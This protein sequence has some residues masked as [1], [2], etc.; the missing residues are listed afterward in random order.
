[1]SDTLPGSSIRRDIASAYVVTA[2][3]V[4]AWVVVSAIIYRQFGPVALG[5]ITLVRATIGIL[6]YTSLGLGPAMVRQLAQVSSEKALVENVSAGEAVEASGVD[7]IAPPVLSYAAAPPPEVSREMIP[8]YATG[9]L[10]ALVSALVALTLALVYS[11]N[12][13]RLHHVSFNPWMANVL[14]A[15]FGIGTVLRLVS[16]P[17]SA[18][19]QTR[20][21]LALDNLLL[22][23]AEALWA[24]LTAAFLYAG[25]SI[26]LPMV[27]IVFALTSAGLLVARKYAA[28]REI[29]GFLH[30]RAPVNWNIAR[31]LLAFGAMIV[32]AQ[33]A[34]F[35][36]AP[37]DC[38]L[39]NHLIGPEAVAWYSPAIQ[40]DAGLLLL[41]SGLAAALY[42]HSSIAH[43]AGD[44][45]R[46]RRYY[47]RGTLASF[48][49]L[50]T[51]GLAVWILSPWM[52][53]LW[54]GEDLP[55]TRAILPLMLIHTIVGG[56]SAVGRAV[57]LAA[58]QAR[59]FTA[60]VLLAGASNVILSYIF[61]R[62]LHLGLRGIVLGTIIVV[63]ARAGIWMPWYVLR[64]LRAK[65]PVETA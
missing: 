18:L 12:F 43:A 20:G 61:V 23:C 40:I 29:R 55:L 36:Y 25:R 15:S 10:L 33:V 21:K 24:A 46:V 27:G 16:E 52:F 4:G 19:L 47:V 38:I 14:A 57:L 2:A 48:A 13:A 3:R 7:P 31:S 64:T 54:F 8:V 53:R 37:T 9:N 56:S 41:V 26:D 39:I 45:Q 65:N 17:A 49:L 22:A 11:T 1:L 58:G 32:I 35:L 30:G 5:V 34:D 51:A 50:T 6:S 44:V 59:P 63:I 62:Y 28:R 42:P 60:A